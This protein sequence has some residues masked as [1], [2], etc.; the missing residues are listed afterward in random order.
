VKFEKIIKHLTSGQPHQNIAYFDAAALK[1]FRCVCPAFNFL[2]VEAINLIYLPDFFVK[3]C[4]K[5]IKSNE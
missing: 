1:K 4:C 2:F 3:K 5:S